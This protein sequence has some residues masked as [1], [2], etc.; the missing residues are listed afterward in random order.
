MMTV[1][2]VLDQLW[3]RGVGLENAVKVL[4][5]LSTEELQELD[6]FFQECDLSVPL[7]SAESRGTAARSKSL[8]LAAFA[9]H[10]SDSLVMLP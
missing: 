10:H 8:F 6:R 1:D 7:A 2:A 3:V 5:D 4:D 9:K